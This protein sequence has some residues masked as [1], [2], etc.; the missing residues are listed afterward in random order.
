[1]PAPLREVRGLGSVVET[2]A[3]SE[4]EPIQRCLRTVSGE[5]RFTAADRVCQL[6]EAARSRSP[7]KIWHDRTLPGSHKASGLQPWFRRGPH[8]LD[9]RSISTF[10]LLGHSTALT[11]MRSR[12]S[13]HVGVRA[14]SGWS[15]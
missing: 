8:L 1:M 5:H 12:W 3:L 2:D 10:S 9:P 14:G 13:S 6:G 7:A 4:H 11:L 15:T